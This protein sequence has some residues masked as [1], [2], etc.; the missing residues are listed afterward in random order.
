MRRLIMGAKAV[1]LLILCAG[2]LCACGGSQDAIDAADEAYQTYNE[3][4]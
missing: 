1:A 3:G 2:V 4:K